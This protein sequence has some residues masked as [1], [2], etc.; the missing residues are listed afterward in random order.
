MSLVLFVMGCSAQS[1]R[2]C[3]SVKSI[4]TS[5]EALYKEV[6]ANSQKSSWGGLFDL[7][8]NPDAPDTSAR[9]RCTM[10]MDYIPVASGSSADP[11]EVSFWTADHCL[12][13]SAAQTTEL[14]LF[15]PKQK[16]YLR[17][18]LTLNELEKYKAGLKLFQDRYSANTAGDT[19][20]QADL[21]LFKESAK[22]LSVTHNSAPLIER[23]AASC[24]ADT[25]AH[26]AANPSQTAVCSTTADLA[27]VRGRIQLSGTGD[28]EVTEALAR[29]AND[30][31]QEDALRLKMADEKV[32]NIGTVRTGFKFFLNQ[33]RKRVEAMT[34]YRTYEGQSALIEK[35]RQCATG[36]FS[37]IC[38]QGFRD[39]F[40]PAVDEYKTWVANDAAGSVRDFPTALHDHIYR[41]PDPTNIKTYNLKWILKVNSE[42]KNASY[43][44][45]EAAVS[46]N[47]LRPGYKVPDVSPLPTVG[48]SGPLYFAL[49]KMIQVNPQLDPDNILAAMLF[50][51]STILIPYS[52]T[53]KPLALALQPGD[54]GSLLVVS[55]LP[56]GVVSTVDGKETSG[57]ASIRPLPEYVGEEEPADSKENTAGVSKNAPLTTCK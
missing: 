49:A 13:F 4:A 31:K 11:L 7:V 50:K 5:G 15:D 45:T 19:S 1:G 35:V 23:G 55:G 52:R 27:H 2:Q 18:N 17:L 53:I 54:S 40:K 38:A 33:W 26:V 6:K 42:I 16:K 3:A 14:H 43:L 34:T 30:L 22:R 47:V 51:T 21:T 8:E 41:E 12:N 56:V 48:E 32:P 36:D 9:S 10:Y 29:M 44:W 24:I 57:G 39:Y 46:T 28:S 25:Q 37:G 20:A